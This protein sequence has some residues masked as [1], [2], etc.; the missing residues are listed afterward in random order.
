MWWWLAEVC[1]PLDGTRHASLRS[2]RCD[3]LSEVFLRLLLPHH[4][5]LPLLS[6]V[7]TVELFVLE[8]YICGAHTQQGSQTAT[9]MCIFQCCWTK[10]SLNIMMDASHP[11]PSL[12][13]RQW[14]TVQ[15]NWTQRRRRG[16]PPLL[17]LV[18]ILSLLQSHLHPSVWPCKEWGNWPMEAG[19]EEAN[20][21]SKSKTQASKQSKTGFACKK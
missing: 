20:K 7:Y 15:D 11:P 17:L 16:A 21:Q 8:K 10:L 4:Q 6:K 3:R 14:N 2:T 9:R 1:L 12:G 19:S 13:S 5:Q 18:A